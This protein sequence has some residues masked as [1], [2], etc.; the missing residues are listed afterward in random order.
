MKELLLGPP[1]A[2][3]RLTGER[4]GKL[5]VRLTAANS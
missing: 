1:L 3:S 5:L 4:L 2:A